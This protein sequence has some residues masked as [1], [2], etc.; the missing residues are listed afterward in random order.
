MTVAERTLVQSDLGIVQT[1][2]LSIPR[3]LLET[4]DSLDSVTI[5]YETYGQLDEDR[6][7]AI[8][9]H[10]AVLQ[11]SYRAQD[12]DNEPTNLPVPI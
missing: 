7:N 8:L 6:A 5:A 4:G 9:V 2:Y 3:L 10:Q 11:L 1:Q 12:P